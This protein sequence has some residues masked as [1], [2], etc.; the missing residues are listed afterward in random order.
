MY[1]LQKKLLESENSL[2]VFCTLFHHNMTSERSCRLTSYIFLHYNPK[3]QKLIFNLTFTFISLQSADLRGAV[4]SSKR[5]HE[6]LKRRYELLQ[7]K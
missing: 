7:L 6:G 2:F 4:M 5:I 3:R 1:S